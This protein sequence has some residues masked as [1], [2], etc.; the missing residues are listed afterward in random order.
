MAEAEKKLWQCCDRTKPK[1]NS[2]RAP[3]ADANAEHGADRRVI[4]IGQDGAPGM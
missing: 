2:A 1:G 4:S 3:T